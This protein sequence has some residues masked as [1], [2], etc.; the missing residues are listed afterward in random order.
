MVCFGASWCARE[1]ESEAPIVLWSWALCLLLCEA[2]R[3]RRLG[4]RANLRRK[5]KEEKRKKED[6]RK[7][8]HRKVSSSPLAV[9]LIRICWLFRQH[10]PPMLGRSPLVLYATLKA[11]IISPHQRYRGPLGAR[12]PSVCVRS[13]PCVL[14]VFHLRSQTTLLRY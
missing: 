5:R 7:R 12:R 2:F 8:V 1:L 9:H 3:R 14:E 4:K 13:S 10:S 6:K 11:F